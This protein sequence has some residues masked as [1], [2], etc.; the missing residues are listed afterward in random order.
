M[1]PLPSYCCLTSKTLIFLLF[2]VKV[3]MNFPCQEAFSAFWDFSIC[4]N[5][6]YIK[7][8]LKLHSWNYFF[9]SAYDSQSI[10]FKQTWG[11]GVGVFLCDERFLLQLLCL[12]ALM[13]CLL[14][15]LETDRTAFWN[16]D[17]L[18]CVW[19]IGVCITLIMTENLPFHKYN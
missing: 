4:E 17:F 8:T 11:I 2:S 10:S 18:V 3:E 7:E 15:N 1:E 9:F 5:L 19:L 12:K 13:H 6:I 14:G 16:D